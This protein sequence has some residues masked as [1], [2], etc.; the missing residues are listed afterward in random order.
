MPT[1]Q[2]VLIVPSGIET[3]QPYVRRFCGWVLIVPSGIETMI[4]SLTEL[5]SP[6]L[7]VPSGI[8]TDDIVRK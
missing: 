4:R 5:N 3:L 6:V 2:S 8:E 7:I 1:Q